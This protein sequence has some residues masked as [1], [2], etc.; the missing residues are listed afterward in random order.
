MSFFFSAKVYSDVGLVYTSAG[1]YENAAEYFEKSLI[2][3]RSIEGDK[4]LEAS[5]CQ[6]LGAVHNQLGS[7]EK[8]I[9]FH[10]KAI[11][12]YGII[13]DYFLW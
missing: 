10:E 11:E 8:A 4:K 2:L 7:Y 3:I 1:Q 12:L 5:V 6:N 9:T 13:S